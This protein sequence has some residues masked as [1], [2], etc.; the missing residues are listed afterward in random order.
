MPGLIDDQE[1]QILIGTVEQ[2]IVKLAQRMSSIEVIGSN[3]EEN[4]SL[5]EK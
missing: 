2:K 5:L 3:L 1:I 4:V